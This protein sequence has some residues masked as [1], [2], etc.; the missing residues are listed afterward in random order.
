[1]SASKRGSRRVRGH[2]KRAKQAVA[3]PI[4]T[5][6]IDPDQGWAIF[7]G[8]KL[9]AC[10]TADNP[11]A[12]RR[13]IQAWRYFDACPRVAAMETWNGRASGGRG[14][15]KA[16]DRLTPKTCFGM[17][18]GRGRWLEQLEIAGY[19][20]DH[21]VMVDA[22]KWQRDM[23]IHR[24]DTKAQSKDWARSI[25]GAPGDMPDHAADAIW[26]GAYAIGSGDVAKMAG[27]RS[28]ARVGVPDAAPEVCI[29]DMWT[30]AAEEGE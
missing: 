19:R 29:G 28:R 26:I 27:K 17:G 15:K 13:V 25:Y 9:R 5:L 10:G 22:T 2:Q 8:S 30:M 1:M 21:V 14:S 16:G 20:A 6:S 23:R 24:G 12:H 3:K 7:D 4:V 11:S 18:A